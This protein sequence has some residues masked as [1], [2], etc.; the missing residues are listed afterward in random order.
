MWDKFQ[1][2]A[3]LSCFS[4]VG[5][6]M[7]RWHP[8]N[9]SS[10]RLAGGSREAT[11]GLASTRWI[12]LSGCWCN[13]FVEYTQNI[14][15]DCT[16]IVPLNRLIYYAVKW[17]Q[18]FPLKERVKTIAGYPELW[19][20]VFLVSF[21]ATWWSSQV[22]SPHIC[23]PLIFMLLPGVLEEENYFWQ[24]EQSQWHTVWL[25]RLFSSDFEKSLYFACYIMFPVAKKL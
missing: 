25:L 4:L 21:S 15:E 12:C 10:Y 19:S 17:K 16:S 20:S 24:T 14:S 2:L 5:M 6:S 8:W 23:D 7:P 22:F 1:L 18:G 9:I 11:S 13:S 3:C